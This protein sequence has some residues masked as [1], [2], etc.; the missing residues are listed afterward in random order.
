M[1]ESTKEFQSY[2][3][4]D[5]EQCCLKF[6]T[7]IL[8]N[9][10]DIPKIKQNLLNLSLKGNA[11]SELMRPF[12]LKILL[13]TLS[14]NKETQLKTWLEETLSRRNEYKEKVKNLIQINKFKGD[15]LGGGENAEGGWNNFFDKTEIKQLINLD[16][17]RTFQDRDLFCEASIKEIEY[18][19]LFLFEEDNQP[20]GY[21]QGMSDILAMLI[22][23]LY[24]YYTKSN[25]KQY[26]NELF[27]KWI[28]D[29]MN[30]IN[31]IYCFFND[32]DEFE[33][34][35]FYLMNNLMKLGINKFYEDS[36]DKDKNKVNYLMK[37]CED[38][39]DLLKIVNNKLYFHFIDIKLDTA[40]IMQRWIKCIF[41][42]E[43]HPKDCSVIWDIIIS[44]EIMH[45]SGE[46]TY[47]N[48]FC[49]A[50]IDFISEELL[51]KDQNDCFQR[52]FSYPPLETVQTLVALA[53]KIRS[54]INND[55]NN[56]NNNKE[57]KNTTNK[58]S[59]SSM[60]DF[61]YSAKSKNNNTTKTNTTTANNNTSNNNNVKKTPNLMFGGDY[62]SNKKKV[63]LFPKDN[64]TNQTTNQISSSNN[65]KKKVPM[66]GIDNNNNNNNSNNKNNNINNNNNNNKTNSNVNNTKITFFD[67]RAYVVSNSENVKSLN[68]LKGIIDQYE[69]EFSSQDKM[70]IGFLIDQIRKEL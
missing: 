66:F 12:S 38:V 67:N 4:N 29:P 27:E 69:K 62:R 65:N 20:I 28:N 36:Q 8:N 57:K 11:E 37:R 25:N 3:K 30:N 32:E 61:L 52:L 58:A 63:D 9:I 16:V 5:V 64:K 33:S 17:D 6:Q 68:E 54:N 34:D 13:N 56:N 53:E 24:P 43:F 18:N 35:L 1:S 51:K 59:Q 70:K 23:T 41:T 50:M 15:P 48:Y 60:A 49:V 19:I 22:F 7:H 31:D 55:D 21:K 2:D 40:V 42:R 10:N 14:S 45:P 44:N 46:F 47:I 26:D 39:F